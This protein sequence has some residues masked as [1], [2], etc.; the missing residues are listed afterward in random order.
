MKGAKYSLEHVKSS[1]TTFMNGCLNDL[2]FIWKIFAQSTTCY[3]TIPL[4]FGFISFTR[5]TFEKA[6]ELKFCNGCLL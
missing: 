2:H 6:F 1:F 3:R 4:I 5:T